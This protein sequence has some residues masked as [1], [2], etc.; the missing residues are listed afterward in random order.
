M[1]N[2]RRDRARRIF[3]RA[4]ELDESD[5]GAFLAGE[6]GDDAE[7][8]QEVR[9][10]LD[11]AASLDSEFL[12]PPDLTGDPVWPTKRS[13]PPRLGD[14]ELHGEIGRGGMGVVYRATQVGLGR[15]VAVKV[16]A[17]SLTT[18]ARDIERFHREARS[19]ASLQHPGIV[20]VF[21]DGVAGDLHYFAME[22]V[23]GHDLA[24]ELRL[25]Q[26]ARASDEPLLL[27]D[28]R[29]PGYVA[30]A[31]R[32]IA[33]A[34]RALQ[35]AHDAGIVHRDVKP[36]NL[37]LGQDGRVRLVDFGVA[38]NEQLGQFTRTSEVAGTP[39]YMS[40]EQ[41][42]AATAVDFRTDVY[43]LGVV[44]YELLTFARPFQGTTAAEI[45]R[46]ICTRDPVPVRRLSPSVPRDLET[47]CHKA[48]ARAAAA[49]YQTAAGLADDLDRF[50]GLQAIAARPPGLRHRVSRLVRRH[51]TLLL[52]AGAITVSV[53]FGW[54]SSVHRARQAEID[55][56]L[57]ALTALSA[58]AD[59]NAIDIELL[60]AGRAH[61][62]A[63]RGFGR[64]TDRTIALAGLENRF[65][66]LRD[67]WKK[68]GVELVEDGLRDDSRNGLEEIDDQRVLEGLFELQR[69]A[70]L[71]P[72]DESIRSLIS[73]ETFSPR[74]TVRA[75]D[76][77]GTELAGTVRCRPIDPFTGQPGEPIDVGRLPVQAAVLAPGYYRIV[78]DLRSRG[79][80]EFARYL[81]RG[82][83]EHVVTA[84]VRPGQLSTGGMLRIDSG[85]PLRIPQ[86]EELC[87]N[88][89]RAV[90]VSPFWI[91]ECEVSVGEYRAFLADTGHQP[92][93]WGW[94]LLPATPE[95]DALPVV[96]VSWDDA[97]AYAE[98]A[99]KRLPTHAE[100]ELAARG[101]DGRIMP[102]PG[103]GYRGNTIAPFEL[104]TD[105]IPANVRTYLALARPV[106]SMPEA[107]TPEGAYHMF[108]NVS[109]WTESE[110]AE[111]VSGRVLVRHD[112]RLILGGTW[113]MQ[114]HG[115]TLTY[116]RHD[117]TDH[118][119][120]NPRR[121]FRCAR[122]DQP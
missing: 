62:A 84:R 38:R 16:L 117:A 85:A 86:Q 23:R 121:G 60:V 36:Q 50:L 107:R 15:E 42:R 40:P 41:T 66:R 54:W 70:Y 119:Y 104:A 12:E 94:D 79:V 26:S 24:H 97:I 39:Y 113:H 72:E 103:A 80:R 108:G 100:W 112:R 5:R 58:I 17:P 18:T 81:P 69:A 1:S 91:D 63:L 73:I 35:Y 83:S 8:L 20:P 33:A 3:V 13:L 102:W 111:R 7:L 45:Q 59:W 114:A 61:L 44:L 77:D 57:D 71:F 87:T 52:L 30:A 88:G 10:L 32:L 9:R 46:A 67:D 122:S 98:W 106:R 78:V 43:S 53:A 56:H 6:C 34:A 95:V 25:Q 28:R 93:P 55:D 74:L 120:A 115:Q 90:E 31:A 11:A 101:A 49:R 2:A 118:N 110:L 48:M 4:F 89:G 68:R 96:Y 47:I 99:G 22:F 14:Y 65:A 27:P 82:P 19:I 64:D 37:L 92:L 51:G 75:A 105:D 116:H 21:G 29:A 76:S 109:E